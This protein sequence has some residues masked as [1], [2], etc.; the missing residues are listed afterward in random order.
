[1]NLMRQ[2]IN[3]LKES[4]EDTDEVARLKNQLVWK[5][6]LQASTHVCNL[7]LLSPNY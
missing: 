4:K 1:M 7:W 6:S 2:E 3:R 5:V